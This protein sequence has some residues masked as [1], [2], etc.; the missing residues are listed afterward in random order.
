VRGVSL[1]LEFEV[2]RY[3]LFAPSTRRVYFQTAWNFED[4]LEVED[5]ETEAKEEANSRLDMIVDML[6]LVK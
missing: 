6:L 3:N 2:L 5:E 1:R 4:A